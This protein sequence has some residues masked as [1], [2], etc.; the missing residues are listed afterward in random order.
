MQQLMG[1]RAQYYSIRRGIAACAICASRECQ[2]LVLGFA[3]EEART[4]GN[5]D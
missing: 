5:M 4:S 1:I 3:I 2:A